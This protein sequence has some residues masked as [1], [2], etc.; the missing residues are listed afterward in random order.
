MLGN[1]LN[2]N[3]SKPMQIN[4]PNHNKEDKK[5]DK[6]EELE[7][8]LL[9]AQLYDFDS[10]ALYDRIAVWVQKP[11]V[12]P[13]HHDLRVSLTQ[14]VDTLI[15]PLPI[16][17]DELE[18]VK[19][20]SKWTLQLLQMLRS[21]DQKGMEYPY[22]HIDN[23]K[24]LE[25]ASKR[26][27]E[28]LDSINRFKNAHGIAARLKYLLHFVHVTRAE[29]DIKQFKTRLDALMLL[30]QHQAFAREL[31]KMNFAMSY[32]NLDPAPVQ[33]QTQTP[34]RRGEAPRR[35]AGR[36]SLFGRK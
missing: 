13:I 29:T 14:K 19:K 34:T 21:I 10:H 18:E 35:E 31:T 5:E 12:K 22:V 24:N 30:C 36:G 25:A 11:I 3:Q 2:N 6:K 7:R 4:S 17:R 32:K 27:K 23:R 26:A 1:N 28:L 33:N 16:T 15:Q 20:L 8:R 9:E